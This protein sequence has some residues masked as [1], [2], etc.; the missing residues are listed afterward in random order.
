[1]KR[2]IRTLGQLRQKIKSMKRGIRTSKLS[3][4]TLK[5]SKRGIRT[6]RFKSM[7]RRI[8]TL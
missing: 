8:K 6:L 7:E 3:K 1:M 2:G 5:S 4:H